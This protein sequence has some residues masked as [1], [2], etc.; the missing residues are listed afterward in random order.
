MGA[1][2]RVKDDC[3]VDIF[4]GNNH[5]D[6]QWHGPDTT[7]HHRIIGI[8]QIDDGDWHL[9][10]A[11]EDIE[12]NQN[13][14][15]VYANYNEV[16]GLSTYYGRVEFIDLFETEDLAIAAARELT[17]A[18]KRQVDAANHIEYDV[19][20]GT[21]GEVSTG[22]WNR[23][24]AQLNAVWMQPVRRLASGPTEP[25]AVAVRFHEEGWLHDM[26]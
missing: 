22:T 23:A 5:S 9:E 7:E 19:N 18:A 24:F 16:N 8:E 13:Y 6:G 17:F 1:R 14:W 10:C 2:I 12:F 21:R 25:K 4:R 26:D 15:L 11:F 3:Y 20:E